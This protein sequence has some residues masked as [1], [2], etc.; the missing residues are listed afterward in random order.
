MTKFTKNAIFYSKNGREL[1][2]DK[3]LVESVQV[4]RFYIKFELV[5]MI[6]DS[7]GSDS[8]GCI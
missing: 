4:A 3:C 1:K 8:N 7:D 5:I 6:N 2:S